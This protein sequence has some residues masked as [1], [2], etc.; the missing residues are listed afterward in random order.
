MWEYEIIN[1]NNP[2]EHDIIYGYNSKDAF[3]RNPDL[4]PTQWIVVNSVYAD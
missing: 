4:D 2:Y 3:R 1:V